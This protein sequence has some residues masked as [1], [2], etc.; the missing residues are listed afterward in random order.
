MEVFNSSHSDAAPK[1]RAAVSSEYAERQVHDVRLARAFTNHRMRLI[2][3][4]VLITV[5]LLVLR[6]FFLQVVKADTLQGVAST[7]R[8][9]SYE[10][11]AKRGD[12]LD[13][14]GAV[15]ATSEPRYNVRVDQQAIADYVEYDDEGKAINGGAAAAAAKLAPLLKRDQAELG[16]ILLGG[17]KKDQWRLLAKGLTPEEWKTVSDLNIHGI[18]PERYMERIYPS[19]SVASPILGFL[20]QT[21][22]NPLPQGQAG[23]E[24]KYND[25]LAGTDGKLTVEVGPDG[26]IFPQAEKK[27]TP[28]V[29]G[30]K[31]QLTI[32]RDLQY[33]A[34]QAV[35]DSVRKFGAVWGSAV[36]LEI[37]TGRILAMADSGNQDPGNTENKS[38]D[39]WGSRAVSS[40]VEPGSTGKIITYA[41]AL[42]EQKITPLSVFNA[43]YAYTTPDGETITDDSEHPTERMTAAGLMAK[44][45]NTG[46]VQVGSLIPTETRYKYLSAFGLGQK[47]GVELPAEEPGLLNPY[48]QWDR[49]TNYTT[50]FG[51]AYAVTPLQLAQVAS[52]AG[53]KGVKNPLHIV[54]GVYDKDGQLI[55]QKLAEKKQVI[56]PEAADQLIKM[57]QGVTQKGSTGPLAKVPGYN[58]AGKTGTAQVLNSA[59]KTAALVGTFAGVVPAENPRIAVAV[60]VYTHSSPAYG[61]VIA[62]PVFAEVSKFA[63]RQLKVPPSAVP[64][65]KYPWLE[66][67]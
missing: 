42:N 16:G 14:N 30:G 13:A 40:V 58:V 31:V 47:T 35:N 44:S 65:Y 51:Q 62:A 61:G 26:T 36:V 20:G 7:F 66:G 23:I 63:M 17:E 49:R 6:L 28:A 60:V 59:G 4:I 54:D 41:T 12:I 64:L 21:A 22:E 33:A 15:L 25:I 67:E 32:D 18:F 46:L 24:Q 43:P 27:E 1:K 11:E 55:P 8:T 37:G 50:M 53:S 57:M 10:Q 52:I 19:G 39:K 56:T 48:T 5:A 9:R 34:E 38:P 45:Y 2:I 3:V 29:N